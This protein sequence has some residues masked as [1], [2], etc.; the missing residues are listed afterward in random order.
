MSVL[1][2]TIASSTTVYSETWTNPQKK[3]TTTNQ[4]QQH[5]HLPGYHQRI[6]SR[7]WTSSIEMVMD[8]SLTITIPWNMPNT[9]FFFK[10]NEWSKNWNVSPSICPIK[11]QMHI[12]P[13][14]NNDK[15]EYSRIIVCNFITASSNL[16]I[17]KYH[18][19]IEILQF[20][21]YFRF[22]VFHT[23]G[24]FSFIEQI[25]CDRFNSV[26][27]SN[28]RIFT[29]QQLMP[30]IKR[31]WSHYVNFNEFI[32]LLWRKLHRII[33]VLFVITK[34]KEYRMRCKADNRASTN[35]CYQIWRVVNTNNK[36]VRLYSLMLS[37]IFTPT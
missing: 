7:L 28:I 26:R 23:W 1:F 30:C 32:H 13:N 24:N 17:L 22:G 6:F 33:F 14:V 36:Y 25:K 19:L 31:S 12:F 35:L 29:G 3:T 34:T 4:T 8:V 18:R 2:T 10:N 27:T 9:F 5:R 21:N 11:L 16:N 15:S 37:I 20:D